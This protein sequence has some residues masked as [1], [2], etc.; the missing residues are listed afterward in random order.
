MRTSGTVEPKGLPLHSANLDPNRRSANS[1]VMSLAF[2]L[3]FLLLAVPV[4]V[5]A[6]LPDPRGGVPWHQ[7]RRDPTDIAP[8][9]ATTHEAVVQVY[10]AQAVS[11]RGVFSV[12]SWIAVKP[13]GAP[14]YTRYEVVGFGVANGAPSIRIDR[15][16]PDNYWFGARPELLLDR[17]GAG[18]DAIIDKIRAAVA[19]YPYPHTYRAWPGPNSNTFTAYIARQVP[20]LGLSL[21]TNAIGKDFLPH[22]AIVAAAPSGT[23]FQLSL[24][25]LAGILIAAR[26]GIE[27]NVLGLATG[28]DAAAPALKLPAI[29][30]LGFR[31]RI[32]PTSSAAAP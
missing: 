21:P 27:I 12:H 15:M 2:L 20:E 18:V 16:G 1:L 26:E 3:L 14:R 8:D 19:S 25:G 11:W 5:S 17:R 7:A 9:P 31:P 29:G 13:T 22:G 4:V 23:G 10:A 30:R 32:V 28:I 6:C 24:Y